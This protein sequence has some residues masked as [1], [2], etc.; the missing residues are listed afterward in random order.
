M[1]SAVKTG[2][3]RKKAP[4][5]EVSRV[6]S[7]YVNPETDPYFDPEGLRKRAF[8]SLVQWHEDGTLPEH[9]L[10]AVCHYVENYEGVGLPA[11]QL[12]AQDQAAMIAEF[13]IPHLKRLQPQIYLNAPPTAATEMQTAL[14]DKDEEDYLEQYLSYENE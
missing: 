11:A 4:A 1:A 14:L 8:P 6:F 10:R 5:K 2:R 7:F 12:F 13:L 9:I 3:K